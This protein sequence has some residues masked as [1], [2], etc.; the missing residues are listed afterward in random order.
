MQKI[1][2]QKGNGLT[3]PHSQPVKT[4]TERTADF[5]AA[6][7]RAAMADTGYMVLCVVALLQAALLALVGVL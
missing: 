7:T 5:I 1:T 3:T 2:T 6:C 4:I